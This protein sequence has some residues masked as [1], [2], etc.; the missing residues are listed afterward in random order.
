MMKQNSS[1]SRETPGET[2][3]DLGHNPYVFIVGC[4]RS[5]TTL[6]QRL[7]DAHPVIAITSETNWVP[8]YFEMK[9]GLT[10]EGLVTPETIPRLIEH[11]RFPPLWIDPGDLERLITPSGHVSYSS[12]VS[13]VF[14]LYR[15]TRGKRLVG[16]KGAGWVR[17]IPTL[18]ALWPEAKF[19]HLIRD[20]RDVYISTINWDRAFKITRRFAAWS[21]DPVTT[22]AFWWEWNVRLG[23]E[24]GGLLEQDLY[25]ELR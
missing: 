15:G 5:G 4:S 3:E 19:A 23:R 13:G 24:S 11:R 14:D 7:V 20:G 16:G 22:A 8:R 25:Y 12:F 21:Q 1:T 10:S 17:H 9:T 6:L 2:S 18:H